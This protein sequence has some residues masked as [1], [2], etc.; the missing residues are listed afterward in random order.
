MAT[1]ERVWDDKEDLT[2]VDEV[3]EGGRR[4]WPMVVNF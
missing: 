3:L 1:R 4:S 2:I